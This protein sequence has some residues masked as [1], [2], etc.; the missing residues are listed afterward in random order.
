[1]SRCLL[2]CQILD[3]GLAELT[4]KRYNNLFLIVRIVAE[5]YKVLHQTIG[6][7]LHIKACVGQHTIPG[8]RRRLLLL[9]LEIHIYISILGW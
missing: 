7:I 8:K 4:F 3:E 1:M 2:V 9:L 6:V 5:L